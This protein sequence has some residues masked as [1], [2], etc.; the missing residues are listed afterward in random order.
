MSCMTESTKVRAGSASYI[1]TLLPVRHPAS[2]TF[3]KPKGKDTSL[4]TVTTI[5]DVLT[6]PVAGRKATYHTLKTNFFGGPTTKY[7]TTTNFLF[8]SSCL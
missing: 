2:H 3:G 4:L 6:V 1:C 5:L 8:V 7:C